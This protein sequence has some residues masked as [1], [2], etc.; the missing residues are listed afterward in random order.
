MIKILLLFQYYLKNNIYNPFYI[1]NNESDLYKSL[2]KQNKTK[3][4]ILYNEKSEIADFY[5]ELFIYLKDAKII[6]NSYSH[7]LFQLIVSYVSYIKFLKINHG[8]KHF[9]VLIAKNEFISS[10]GNKTNVICSSPFEYELL[11]KVFKYK[12]TY[13]HNASLVRYDRFQFLKKNE[14][15][16]PCILASFTYRSYNNSIFQN[17]EYK[18]N[19]EELLNDKKLIMY[20]NKKN[21]ELI[22]IPHHQEINLGKNY[23]QDIYKYAQIKNQ[24]ELEHYIEQ[25]SLLITDF[26]SISFDFMFQNKPVLFYAIDKNDNNSFNQGI[27]MISPNDTFYFGNY[28]S[29]KELIIEKIKYYINNNFMIGN[30]LKQKYESLFFIKK[31]IIPKIVEIINNIISEKS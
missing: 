18:K 11:T 30:Q 25:C 3:N 26:S 17:S 29:K 16:K 14:T 24:S 9:K 22:Y 31:N 23:S 6:I 19:L 7:V 10:L 21:I 5:K 2:V 1:I 20:L 8:I 15:E 28:Y 27:N 13:I 12:K 4:L